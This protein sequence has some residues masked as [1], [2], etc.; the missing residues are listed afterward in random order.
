MKNKSINITITQNELSIILK[1]MNIELQ[2]LRCQLDDGQ[3][4]TEQIDNIE[5]LYQRLSKYYTKPALISNLASKQKSR[6]CPTCG[7][8]I[9]HKHPNA[10][11]CCTKCKDRYHNINNPRGYYAPSNDP[12]D[13]EHPFSG[14]ATGQWPDL[15]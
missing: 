5:D 6:T 8:S 11:F 4:L 7:K 1:S 2:L 12:E 14:V 3:G 10:R 13:D 15:H 9:T